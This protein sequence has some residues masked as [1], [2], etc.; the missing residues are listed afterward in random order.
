LTTSQ[1]IA[2]RFAADDEVEELAQKV[3]AGELNTRADI[4]RAIHNWRP[5]DLRV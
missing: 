1:L 5:D 2:L 3:I 4:K